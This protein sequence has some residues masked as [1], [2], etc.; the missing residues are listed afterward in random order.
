MNDR[1]PGNS[2]ADFRHDITFGLSDAP[3]FHGV[4]GVRNAF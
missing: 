4:G 3:L 2:S 1:L